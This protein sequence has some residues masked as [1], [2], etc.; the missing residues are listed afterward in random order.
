MNKIELKKIIN[1][2]DVEIEEMQEAYL[3]QKENGYVNQALYE[4]ISKLWKEE[5]FYI[6]LLRN[7]TKRENVKEV[8]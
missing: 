6:E 5:D 3:L 8:K 4:K 1:K 7:I 2:M